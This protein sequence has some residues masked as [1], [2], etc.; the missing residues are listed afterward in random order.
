[1]STSLLYH[2][3]SLRGY[4]YLKTTFDD[5]QIIF[6]VRPKPGTLR[7]SACGRSD[8]IRHGEQQRTFQTVPIGSKRVLLKVGIPRLECRQCG[9]IRQARLSFADTRRKYTKAFERHVLE[10]SQAMT[11]R[12]VARQLGVGWDTIKDIQKRD[13]QRRFKKIRLC[14]LQQIAID[15]IS[16]GKGH[17]YVTIVL[18]LLSGAVVF[19]GEGKDALSWQPFWKQLKASRARIRAVAT[20]MSPAYIHAVQEN[21]SGAVHVFDHFHVIKLFN[22]KLSDFRRTL[23][24]EAVGPLGKKVLKGTRLAALEK[25]GEPGPQTPRA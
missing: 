14:D 1:M 20:D 22:E 24:H 7:C 11:I 13:L 5:G 25:P 16:I 17:R 4:D 6:A 18:D 10:L 19:I 12:D 9:K 15:E 23:Y 8:V 21:L 3:F 2:G